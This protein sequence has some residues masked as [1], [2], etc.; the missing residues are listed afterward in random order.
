MALVLA[1]VSD[2]F[3]KWQEQQMQLMEERLAQQ[4]DELAQ[5]DSWS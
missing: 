3:E 1:D 2:G 4:D 5:M